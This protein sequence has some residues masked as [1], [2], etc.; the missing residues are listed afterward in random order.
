LRRAPVSARISTGVQTRVFGG[1][2]RRA[3]Y[4]AEHGRFDGLA[5]LPRTKEIEALPAGAAEF[6][7]AHPAPS[8]AN[9]SVFWLRIDAASVR[10]LVLSGDREPADERDREQQRNRQRKQDI[11]NGRRAR[12]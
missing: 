9:R 12:V 2:F 1:L 7:V 6:A 10:D 3:K 8:T 11:F 5:G 4:I